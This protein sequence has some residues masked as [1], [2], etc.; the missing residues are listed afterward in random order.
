VI[1]VVIDE[2]RDSLEIPVGDR[3][4]ETVG[5]S[6]AEKLGVTE[7]SA[8]K[9]P[10]AEKL[11]LRDTAALKELTIDTVFCC[12]KLSIPVEVCDSYTDADAMP[13]ILSAAEP[14]GV[15]DPKLEKLPAPLNVSTLD[16]VIDTDPDSVCKRLPV[17]APV[18]VTE[19]LM[20]VVTVLETYVVTELE[21]AADEVTEFLGLFETDG[22]AVDEKERRGEAD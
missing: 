10:L 4:A 14:D 19:A 2:M 15:G 13:E 6:P 9:L 1:V 8:V 20:V 17:A 5:D 12:E 22:F 3:P 18:E 16:T 21:G 11:G 7:T